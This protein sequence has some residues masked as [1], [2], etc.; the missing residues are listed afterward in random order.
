MKKYRMLK[1]WKNYQVNDIVEIEDETAKALVIAEM[2]EEYDEVAEKAASEKAAAEEVKI[3]KAVRKA[4]EEAMKS[5]SQNTV[6]VRWE[7]THEA[8]DDGFTSIGDQLKAVK[9]F[10]L[11]GER[12]RQF[13]GVERKAASG[14]NET[15]DED[16]G[17]LVDPDIQKELSERIYDSG[18]LVSRSSVVEVS[19]NGLVWREL[20]DYDRTS[21]PVSV[22][23]TEEAGDKTASNPKFAERE[24][25]L[26]KLAGLFYT[27]DELNEDVTALGS[28][29]DR[30]FTR[31][32]GFV[33]DNAIMRGTGAGMPLGY[34][35]S[36][37]VVTVSK[38]GSQ[39]A[40]TIVAT[41]V[42][43]MFARMP[44]YLSAGA[45]WLINQDAWGQ[46]PGMTIG[47]Q[48]VFLNPSG[49]IKAAPGGFLYGRPVVMCEHCS[50]LG[51]LGDIQFVNL[52]EYIL[53]KKGLLKTD[54][55][56][57]VRFVQDE[58]AYRF[59]MRVNGQPA[60]STKVTPYKGSAYQSPFVQLE[61][62]T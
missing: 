49:D 4:I 5:G 45:T 59:V 50:T 28:M 2:I 10:A 34:L 7:V 6:N 35:H 33:L 26:R 53:I 47:D 38:V 52:A 21:R 41:N 11:S 54:V 39:T 22:Y 30:W 40:D 16:G 57:H 42:S 60:W 17:F 43:N 1:T 13:E 15:I 51:D 58:T 8:E 9:A 56:I 12:D 24:M 61:A 36:D 25:R 46:L 62:R 29:V 20:K 14:A 3:S 18:I 37:A 27:T 55:S 32:F 19:G 23:W 48:P 31:E 44:A